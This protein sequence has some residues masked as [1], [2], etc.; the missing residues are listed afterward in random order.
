MYT[1]AGLV[2]NVLD[3]YT[4]PSDEVS[5]HNSDPCH[6]TEQQQEVDY[7]MYGLSPDKII[8][9]FGDIQSFITKLESFMEAHYSTDDAYSDNDNNYNKSSKKR[10]KPEKSRN[11]NNVRN[12]KLPKQNLI[13][14]QANKLSYLLDC[15]YNKA[16][17]L[18][19]TGYYFICN[20]KESLDKAKRLDEEVYNS[21]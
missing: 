1:R 12:P 5:P 8:S 2:S 15:Y 20:I 19:A 11:K 9:Y 6:L 3:G 16:T 17:D 7:D 4:D 18:D 10:L 13:K 14:L 21:L